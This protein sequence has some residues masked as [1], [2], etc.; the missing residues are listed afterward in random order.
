M[1]GKEAWDECL[2][3]R[4]GGLPL[5]LHSIRRDGDGGEGVV[6]CSED[7]LMAGSQLSLV[8]GLPHGMAKKPAV[9]KPGEGKAGTE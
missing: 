4:G 9:G 1:Q 7:S 3:V 6:G 8:P 5:A 2:R